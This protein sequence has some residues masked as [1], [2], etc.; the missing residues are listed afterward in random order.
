MPSRSSGRW[1]WTLAFLAALSDGLGLRTASGTE[2][3]QY[4]GSGN[5]PNKHPLL[6]FQTRLHDLSCRRDFTHYSQCATSRV[7]SLTRY[8]V[9]F[10]TL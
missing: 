9:R 5:L 2:Y 4:I 3:G 8:Y 1:G 7:Y 10:Y 6:R